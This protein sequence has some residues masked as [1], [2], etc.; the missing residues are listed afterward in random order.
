MIFCMKPCH[1]PQDWSSV[2]GTLTKED[3]I[4]YTI[5]SG[6]FQYLIPLSNMK[7]NSQSNT[8]VSSKVLMSVQIAPELEICILSPPLNYILK[9]FIQCLATGNTSKKLT[10]VIQTFSV[11][12]SLLYIKI[13]HFINVSISNFKLCK[14]LRHLSC[15]FIRKGG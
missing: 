4:W 14:F 7:R 9:P 15:F 12:I 1:L 8:R 10:I 13:F 6:I 2:T 3:R 11:M 5:F